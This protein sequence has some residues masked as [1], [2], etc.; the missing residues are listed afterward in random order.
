MLFDEESRML[1][2]S[3]EEFV[4]DEVLP[5]WDAIDRQ[6]DGV[7]EGLVRA[8][9]VFRLAALSRY[10]RNP[11]SE[12]GKRILEIRAAPSRTTEPRTPRSASPSPPT[13]C[14]DL[15]SSL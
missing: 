4:R 11:L 1:G 5:K 3:V 14:S 13:P 2:A 8:R 10:A 7:L 6:E 12:N 9:C 15:P